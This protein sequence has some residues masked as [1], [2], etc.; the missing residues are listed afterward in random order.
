VPL[1]R[2]AQVEP[3]GRSTLT[4][5]VTALARAGLVERVI[6][7]EDRRHLLIR[8]TPAGRR[9]A[10]RVMRSRCVTLARELRVLT[11]DDVVALVHASRSADLLAWRMS[12]QPWQW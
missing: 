9:L 5:S 1:G 8:P 12:R 6:D 11:A 3:I 7:P 10:G 4:R 2:I